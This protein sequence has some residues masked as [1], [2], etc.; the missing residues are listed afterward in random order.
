MFSRMKRSGAS[1]HLMWGGI[2][3]ASGHRGPG[4][5]V[6]ILAAVWVPAAN[7][8]ADGQSP[9]L[10][11][12]YAGSMGAVMDRQ[13]F[14]AFEKLNHT[15]VRGTGRGAIGLARQLAA[16]EIESDVF[17]PV[18]RA[19]LKL[20]RPGQISGKPVPIARTCMVLAYC[21]RG[22]AAKLFQAAGN[23]GE[24]W[25]QVLLQHHLRFG[26]TD[27]RTDPQGR[28]TV[29]SLKLAERYYRQAG[30]AR[31]IMGPLENPAQIFTES[32]LM[33]RLQAG[34]VDACITYQSQAAANHLPFIRL[35]E[36]V[37]LGYPAMD[38]KWYRRA[39]FNMAAA[40]HKIIVCRAQPLVFYAA[41]LRR[42]E[43]KRL[44]ESFV[45]FLRSKT[46][47][48]MFRSAG[49]IPILVKQRAGKKQS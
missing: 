32:S 40:H 13:I 46:C 5:A 14:P 31:R 23:P 9:I 44:A 29:L 45:R 33:F 15:T 22:P 7:R 49:Y 26:R 39:R 48:G 35:P 24:P 11:V 43:N 25:Y 16:G 41:V 17:I 2:R 21:P 30:L 6:L 1:A 12:C 38:A 37:N 20:L 47:Q 19:P 34:Q 42:A 28:S 4:M 36:Q 10:R 8:R 18:T 27:P 3:W